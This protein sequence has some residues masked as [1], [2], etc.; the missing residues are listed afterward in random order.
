MKRDSSWLMAPRL[1]PA[2]D[3]SFRPA[4][5]ANRKFLADALATRNSVPVKLAL[6]QA[7][8]SVFHFDTRIFPE[9]HPQAANN[10]VCLERI[11][12]F[13]LW[14]RGSFRIHFSGPKSLG[15]QLQKHF[16]ERPTGVFDAAIMGERI[17]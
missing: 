8:G 4:A 12:K 3:P 1:V 17:Y 15:E 9:G 6:E 14:S 13:L 11:V 10:F 2:L 16:R 5:L 7:D